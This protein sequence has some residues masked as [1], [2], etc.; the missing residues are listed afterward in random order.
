MSAPSSEPPSASGIPTVVGFLGAGFGAIA[1]G[2]GFG[3]G[4]YRRSSA[5]KELIEKFPEPP[6][7]EM[8]ALARHG[9]GRALAGGT[10]LAAL[11]GIGAVVVARSNGVC[12]VQDFADA[13]RQ[14]LPTREGLEGSM[15][16]K[17]EPLQ[18]TITEHFQPARNASSDSFQ[19][20]TLGRTL[21][22]RAEQSAK[23]V[24]PMEPWEKE[25]VQALE[26]AEKAPKKA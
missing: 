20:S 8:E 12:T 1:F 14:W 2:A 3:A 19:T 5:Y 22:K 17:L 11:M 10:A 23:G 13:M 4:S 15:K 18:R 7:A 25:I 24:K 26:A 21:S 9:A 16:P 6:T